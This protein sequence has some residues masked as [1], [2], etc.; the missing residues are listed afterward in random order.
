ME[1]GKVNYMLR[2]WGRLL[3]VAGMLIGLSFPVRSSE[4]LLIPCDSSRENCLPYFKS[5]LKYLR[6][7]TVDYRLLSV[8]H[9]G[10]ITSLFVDF[11]GDEMCQD[12]LRMAGSD[13]KDTGAVLEKKVAN[14]R[15]YLMLFNLNHRLMMS[16]AAGDGI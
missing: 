4:V 16:C 1:S 10:R 8:H 11:P 5:M 14:G 6:T 15:S 12:F 3:L 13:L 9:R 2:I 7:F